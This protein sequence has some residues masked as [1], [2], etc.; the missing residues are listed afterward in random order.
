[1]AVHTLYD[2]YDREFMEFIGNKELRI[3]VDT[4]T[5]EALGLHARS[6]RRAADTKVQ[7]KPAKGG[8]TLIS[9][10]VFHRQYAQDF[11]TPYSVGLVELDEGPR[12]LAR[13]AQ[14]GQKEP[15]VGMHVTAQFDAGGL[16]FQA[17]DK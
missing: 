17:S 12:L 15:T 3:A 4:Q 5:G 2:D 14:A 13:L 10:V 16:F 11:P 7:W 9:Y 1:M 8:G 6:W